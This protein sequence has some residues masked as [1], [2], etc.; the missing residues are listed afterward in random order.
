[1]DNDKV[2]KFLEHNSPY[3]D[4]ENIGTWEGYEVYKPVTDTDEETN[5][6]LVNGDEIRFSKN[7]ET[8]IIRNHFK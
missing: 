1:M 4:C 2:L 3:E 6:V 8:S 7:P 5:F